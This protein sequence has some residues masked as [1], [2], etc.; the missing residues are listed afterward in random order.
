MMYFYALPVPPFL[1]VSSPIFTSVGCYSLF[2]CYHYDQVVLKYM[3]FSEEC[4]I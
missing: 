2:L 3:K 4:G 1:D